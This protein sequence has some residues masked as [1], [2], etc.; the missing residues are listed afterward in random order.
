MKQ[1]RILFAATFIL[2]VI[3]GISST[4]SSTVQAGDFSATVKAQA[5]LVQFLPK[6][7]SLW[8]NVRTTELIKAG[9]LVRT[10][11][12]GMAQ[13]T[14][15]TGIEVS[16]YP[17]SVVELKELSSSTVNGQSFILAQYVGVLFNNFKRKSAPNDLLEVVLPAAGLRVH[18]TQYWSVLTP[19]FEIGIFGQE[20]EVEVQG[21]DGKRYI[22]NKDN[23]ARIV[24]KVEG[25]P[26]ACT[27][28]Y[29]QQN[30]KSYLV[31]VLTTPESIESIRAYLKATL[32]GRNTPTYREY[33]R[34][35]TG[36]E[37]DKN[38]LD[39]L[40]KALDTYDPS[41]LSLSAFLEQYRNFLGNSSSPDVKAPIAAAS[42]GNGKQDPG[43]TIGSCPSDFMV[44]ARCGD[45]VCEFKAADGSSE[46]PDN[47]PADC[48]PKA[49]L[50]FAAACVDTI[51][52]QRPTRTP[53]PT[54]I[55][56]SRPTR[57]P[58]TP[59]GTQTPTPSL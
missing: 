13:L 15:A 59:V 33:L 12:T 53:T 45:G 56:G 35:L 10:S 51:I 50:G 52:G 3:F 58:V 34:I 21:A 46:G 44:A 17:G 25:V 37:K 31:N 39:T 29:L 26:P 49:G 43:E 9:D 54:P 55:G 32:I 40:L 6:G 47:C 16:I 20:S 2:V 48:L 19:A 38:D 30:V 27:V 18:G 23:V 8:K 24:F 5:G 57:T 36:L 1:F 4:F 7:S 11:G 42:C 41:K 22:G 28:D 14:T